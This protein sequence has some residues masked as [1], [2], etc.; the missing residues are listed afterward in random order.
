MSASNAFNLCCLHQVV[1][2]QP[3]L[4]VP[5]IVTARLLDRTWRSSAGVGA[6]S[7]HIP[8]GPVG[9]GVPV[10]GALHN[11]AVTQAYVSPCPRATF[12]LQKFAT[13]GTYANQGGL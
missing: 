3:D 12:L 8:R 4:I 5:L 9:G 10:G 1:V 2:S 13:G 7:Q 11:P 6:C